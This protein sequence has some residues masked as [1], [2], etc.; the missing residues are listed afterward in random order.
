ML[1]YGQDMHSI[2]ILAFTNSIIGDYF[3]GLLLLCQM[4]RRQS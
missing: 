4:L 2:Y 1:V 3:G